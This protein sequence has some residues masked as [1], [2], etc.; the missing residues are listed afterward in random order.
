MDTN[1]AES[2]EIWADM[3]EDEKVNEN[4]EE[5]EPEET[6]QVEEMDTCTELPLSQVSLPNNET[7]EDESHIENWYQASVVSLQSLQLRPE[8]YK[9]KRAMLRV[10]YWAKM[11]KYRNNATPTVINF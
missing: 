3:V 9:R 5:I 10:E 1:I 6:Q 4:E 2:K 8:Q 11:D 7:V